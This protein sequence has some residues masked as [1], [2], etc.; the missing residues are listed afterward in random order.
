MA[1]LTEPQWGG[2]PRHS[3]VRVW[4]LWPVA[5]LRTLLSVSGAQTGTDGW[6]LAWGG[7]QGSL[8]T[9]RVAVVGDSGRLAQG[10]AG[11]HQK[12]AKP[13]DRY[14]AHSDLD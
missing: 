9:D 6:V 11:M 14:R 5:P 10:G 12:Q 13:E 1:W 7:A 2:C 8:G 4:R 3:R